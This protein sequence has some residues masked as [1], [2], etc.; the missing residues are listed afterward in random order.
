MAPTENEYDVVFSAMGS[1]VRLLIGEPEAVMKPARSVADEIRRFVSAFEKALSRFEP[2]SELCKL[3]EDPRKCVPS[4]ELLREVVKA[5]L[6]AAEWSGGLVDP[7]L[8]DAIE[9]VGY[10]KSRARAQRASL[11][12]AL[13][14]APPRRPAKP[15]PRSDWKRIQVDDATK[16]IIRPPGVRID[17]GGVG[18]GLAADLISKHLRG[19]PRFIVDC[20]GDIR[21][22][23]PDAHTVPYEVLVQHPQTGQL[24]YVLRLRSGAVATSAINV[25]IWQ[26]SEGHYAHHLL[27]PSTGAPAWTGL[28]SATAIGHTTLEAETLAKVALLSGP[29]GGRVVLARLGGLLVHD[30][31]RIEAAGPLRANPGIRFPTP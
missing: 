5:G 29:D 15:N 9:S 31:G 19:Y 21:I 11:E 7:T 18:K 25:R 24:P 23:G 1:H 13:S 6:A 27:D 4:S 10:A 30:S 2:E 12:A 17:T 20:G 26:A 16:T 14:E 28:T 3:N 22:G 8:V